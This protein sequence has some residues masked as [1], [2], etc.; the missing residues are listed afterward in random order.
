MIILFTA[1]SHRIH[2][3]VQVQR[4]TCIALLGDHDIYTAYISN[5]RVPVGLFKSHPEF[6]FLCNG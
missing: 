1:I 3:V 4:N 5:G 2:P 6:Y